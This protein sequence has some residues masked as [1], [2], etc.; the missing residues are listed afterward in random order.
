M[1]IT[2][3]KKILS[4]PDEDKESRLVCCS[5][6]AVHE[7]GAYVVDDSGFTPMSEAVKRV[8]GGTLSQAEVQAMYDVPNGRVTKGFRVPLDRRANF[9]GDI[10]EVSKA[11]RNAREEAGEALQ[12]SYE[13]FQHE[14]RL[15]EIQG[16]NVSAGSNNQ[17]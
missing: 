14:Q 7:Y 2:R 11:A 16:T 17:K 6:L 3:Y 10:A 1:R 12:Q 8:T 9:H 4:Y 5:N 15:A 13:Q